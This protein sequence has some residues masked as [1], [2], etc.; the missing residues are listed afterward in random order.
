MDPRGDADVVHGDELVADIEGKTR[1]PEAI[2]E[3]LAVVNVGGEPKRGFVLGPKK[4]FVMRI[5][6][7]RNLAEANIVN[8][9][10]FFGRVWRNQTY[11]SRLRLSILFLLGFWPCPS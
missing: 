8:G 2:D 5:V 1:R 3:H 7:A 10:F 11:L 6:E 4:E 9:A